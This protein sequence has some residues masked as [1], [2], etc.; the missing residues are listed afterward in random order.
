MAADGAEQ[1]L[2]GGLPPGGMGPRMTKE[3]M[4]KMMKQTQGF[5]GTRFP[6]ILIHRENLE[7]MEAFE[8]R[9]DDIFIV[10]YPKCGM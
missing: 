4:Q 7:A 3:T 2:A 9:E 8:V 10:T 5:K 6:T 1:M